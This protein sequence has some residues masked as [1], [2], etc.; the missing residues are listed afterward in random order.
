MVAVFPS[1]RA[2]MRGSLG[3]RH[4][5]RVAFALGIAT[6][7]ACGG[8]SAHEQSAVASGVARIRAATASYRV[9][10]SAVAVGY[11]RDV[12]NCLAHPGH[13]AMGYHHVRRDLVD[14]RVELERPEILL[15]SRTADGRYTLNG[16]EYIVPYRVLPRE[17]DP[18]VLLGNKLK[19]SDSLQ[20][21]YLHAWVWQ[22]NP[23]G[24]FADWNA[25]VKC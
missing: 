5:R 6:L 2:R 10:D 7:A 1:R 15:Y 18:P 8:A 17:S 19:Q 25:E 24:L 22:D 21:W 9:L 12:K 11:A 16:V 4:T 23:A 20:L 14:G 13:G 3:S